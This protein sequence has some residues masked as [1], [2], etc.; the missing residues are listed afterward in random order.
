MSGGLQGNNRAALDFLRW[1]RPGGPWVLTAITP[2]RGTIDTQTFDESHLAGLKKWLEANNGSANCYFMVNAARGPL[3]KKASKNDVEAL[4]FLHVDVDAPKE[5]GT[6]DAAAK[7]E[8]AKAAILDSLEAFSPPPSCIID[9]G[10]GYQGFWRL[11]EPLFVGGN[12]QRAEEVETYNQQLEIVFKGDHCWNSDRIMRLPG[13]IN[14]P[15]KKKRAAGRVPVLAEIVG[16]LRDIAY[17]L[18]L[19]TPAPR[20]NQSSK[21]STSSAP[22]VVIDSNLPPVLIDDLPETVS[23]RIKALI[24][25][26]NDPD[27]PTKYSSRSEATWAAMCGLLRAGC[28]DNVVASI[29]LDKDYAIS[30]H[31]LAQRRPLEYVARQIERAKEEIEEP[32]LRVLNDRHAV[33]HDMGGKC[34]IISE[35]MDHSVT[36]PRPKI[37][38]QSFDDFRNRYMNQRVVV[39]KDDKGKPITMPVGKW[40]LLHSMRREY[41]TMVFAPN[42]E[43]EGSYNLWKGFACEALPGSNHEPFLNHLLENICSGN[44]EHYQYLIHWMARGVQQPDTQGE[45]AVVMRGGKG[46]G[47]GTVATTYGSLWGRHW[48]HVSSAKHLVGQ[49]NVHLRDCC[50]VFADEAFFAG[51]K[52][53]AGVLQTIITEPTL[54]VEPKGVDAEMSP[55]YLHLMMSS[56]QDW[57]VPASADE[58]RYF[59]L[60]V[61]DDRKQNIQYFREIRSALK[62]GGRENLLHFLLNLD[63][64]DFEVRDVPQTSGLQTQKVQSMSP[65]E[66]WWLE[67]LTDG[68]TVAHSGEWQPSLQKHQLFSD[69]LRFM[70]AQRIFRRATPTSLGIFLKKILPDEYPVG[71]QKWT[72]VEKDDGRGGTLIARERVY[73]Y[74]MPSL[75]E[76]RAY[77]ESKF[78]AYE[79]PQE[80][81]QPRLIEEEGEP[82]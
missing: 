39:G 44:E 35:T 30:A 5:A 50:F 55:N 62:N 58:R 54:M 70:E 67:R 8:K 13:T 32:W 65:E 31:V 68:R 73:F 24:V 27:E 78:G 51:D 53:H 64:S 60:D 63:L 38:K 26:G 74:D 25:Q 59:V 57:V 43:I 69:Y 22:R 21:P 45:V 77:W 2:D 40:W 81:G 71:V 76:S 52:Q 6:T 37:S 82:Y 10:G 42:R 28:D 16:E 46:A 36:P 7:L 4:E 15:D 41:T 34:R 23:L 72:D 47:K 17:A 11:D 66:S 18:D 1:L 3:A 19:F 9:S 29:F 12:V 49:F 48:L 61:S 79:W 20:Q 33:I 56:N 80:E 14:L 75:D